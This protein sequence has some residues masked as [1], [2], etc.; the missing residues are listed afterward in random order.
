MARPLRRAFP[1]ALSHGTSRGDR[2]EAL[3]EDEDDRELFLSILVEVVK[4]WHGGCS[5]SCLMRTHD[6]LLLA[7]PDGKL[8][9]GMRQ[10]N[11]V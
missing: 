10:L 8:A 9:Q 5:P 3:Y 11:G 1:G 7:T 2:Q 4:G 6:P